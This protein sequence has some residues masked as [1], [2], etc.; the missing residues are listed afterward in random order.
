PLRAGGDHDEVE[1]F[2]EF[3]YI[4]PFEPLAQVHVSNRFPHAGEF[5]FNYLIRNA[6]PRDHGGNFPAQLRPHVVDNRLMSLPAQ[7]PGNRDTRR[8][9][10]DYRDRSEEHTSELQSP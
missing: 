7:L 5:S 9:A 4:G 2:P 10:A 8:T 6:R 1:F 3:F